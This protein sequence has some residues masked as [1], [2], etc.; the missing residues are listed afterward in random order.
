MLLQINT[1]MLHEMLQQVNVTTNATMITDE[2]HYDPR[3][4]SMLHKTWLQ[5]LQAEDERLATQCSTPASTRA[6]S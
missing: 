1:I 4:V 5:M 3:D 2:H 6:L